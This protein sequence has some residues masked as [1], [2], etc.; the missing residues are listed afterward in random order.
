MLREQ[1][2][3]IFKHYRVT[4]GGGLKNE[5][6]KVGIDMFLKGYSPEESKKELFDL[7]KEGHIIDTERGVDLTE[8]GEK[9][10]YGV[11]D[12][13]GSINEIS[14]MFQFFDTAPNGDLPFTSIYAKKNDLLSPI[15]IKYLDEVLKECETRG[16]VERVKRGLIL[17]KRF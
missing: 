10:V 13:N 4:G 16:Y 8:K 7:V 12:I 3:Q 14:K 1:I 17:K 2:F 5:H 11:F 15:T 6:L 9:A